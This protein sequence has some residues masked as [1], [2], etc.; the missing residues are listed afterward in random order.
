[1]PVKGFCKFD[2]G[3]VK[4]ELRRYLVH[5]IFF[6]NKT[7]G[8]IFG[9]QEQV[10]PWCLIQISPEIVVIREFIPAFVT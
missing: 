4:N 6:Y 2:E 10:T 7:K 5:N 9:A 8:N 1:M 3:P